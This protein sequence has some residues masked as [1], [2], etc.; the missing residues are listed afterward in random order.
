MELL[1]VPTSKATPQS[2]EDASKAKHIMQPFL[3]KA[4]P[5]SPSSGEESEEVGVNAEINFVPS[6]VYLP[7]AKRVSGPLTVAFNL[8]PA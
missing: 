5:M 2:P 4:P 3:L 7:V 8:T 1:K 6:L